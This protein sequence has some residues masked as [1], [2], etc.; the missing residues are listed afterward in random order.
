[1]YYIYVLYSKKLNKI[2]KGITDDLK[3]RI[4]RHN[5]GRVRSTKFGVPWKLVYYEAF[6]NK[7]DAKREELYLKSG[8]G[9]ERLKY[10]LKETLKY[11]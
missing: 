6:A 1:M 10:L 11:K 2:Y 7:S 8:K 9:R 5:L 4:S 3:S